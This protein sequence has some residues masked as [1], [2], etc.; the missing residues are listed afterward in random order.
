V[1]EA[2]AADLHNASNTVVPIDETVA[3]AEANAEIEGECKGK[4]VVV[5]VVTTTSPAYSDCMIFE[6][7]SQTHAVGHP[8]DRLVLN[9]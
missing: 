8:V 1:P 2:I 7:D 6:K 5:A 4:G 9:S 3:A